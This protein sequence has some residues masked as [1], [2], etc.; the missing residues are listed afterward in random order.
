MLATGDSA[1]MPATLV[2]TIITSDARA[3]TVYTTVHTAGAGTEAG[4]GIM[5]GIFSM[6]GL[7]GTA[8]V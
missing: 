3:S 1:F 2:A 8:T 7:T 4:A 5:A 6:A